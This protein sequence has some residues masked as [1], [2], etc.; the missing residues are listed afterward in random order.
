MLG[1]NAEICANDF[2]TVQTDLNYRKVW[3][4]LVIKIDVVDQNKE[5][6]EEVLRWITA[7]PVSA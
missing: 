6:K 5:T 7:Y 4:K 3:D 1:R 2:F